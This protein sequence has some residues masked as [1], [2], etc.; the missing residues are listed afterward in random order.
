M[1]EF[2]ANSGSEHPTF[3]SPVIM[4]SADEELL[5]FEF[6]SLLNVDVDGT[7]GIK[8]SIHSEVEELQS[9]RV[10]VVG[11]YDAWQLWASD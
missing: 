9:V 4:P 1:S 5:S 11:S 3:S 6:H 2:L 8:A 7:V 10:L